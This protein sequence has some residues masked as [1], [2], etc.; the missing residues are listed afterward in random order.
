VQK[1]RTARI[2]AQPIKVKRNPRTKKWEVRI[3]NPMSRNGYLVAAQWDT[4]KDAVMDALRFK[5]TKHELMHH[6]SIAFDTLRGAEPISAKRYGEWISRGEKLRPRREALHN[7]PV[8]LMG[9]RTWNAETHALRTFIDT[10][11]EEFALW[12]GVVK[13]LWARHMPGK[14]SVI[15]DA[16]VSDLREYFN[17]MP[18]D[19]LPI[20]R[21]EFILVAWK[22][23]ADSLISDYPEAALK[24]MAEEE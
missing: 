21:K 16:F 22:K 13:Q 24:P 23:L 20:E 12:H 7:I 4:M 3:P 14:R 15:V 9:I 8:P 6:K 5:P 11:N 17:S 1:S 2:L 19:L 10:S 18:D